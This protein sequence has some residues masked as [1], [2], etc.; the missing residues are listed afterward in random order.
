MN[1]TTLTQPKVPTHSSHG[2]KIPAIGFGTSQLGDC[3]EV[4]AKALELGYRHID[5]AWK[6]GSEKGARE[7]EAR[8]Q[9]APYR[10]RELQHRARR[11]SDAA[12]SGTSGDAAGRISPLSGSIQSARGMPPVGHRVHRLLP[13]RAR[14][15]FQRCRDRRDR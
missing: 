2:A 15:P 6:Y 7:S 13:A 9:D 3:G 4:I 5:T 11:R 12:L 1:E 8:R 10:R 14:A